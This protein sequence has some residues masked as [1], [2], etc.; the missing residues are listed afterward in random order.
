VKQVASFYL[1]QNGLQ[2]FTF[3]KRS[4]HDNRDYVKN[5]GVMLNS[6]LHFHRYVEYLYYYILSCQAQ[7]V[8]SLMDNPKALYIALI[9]QRLNMRLLPG[10]TLLQ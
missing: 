1:V 7:F 9:G 8:S 2:G 6:K 10:I 3:K 4:L 5:L